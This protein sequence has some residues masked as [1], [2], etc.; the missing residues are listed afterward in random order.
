MARV[1]GLAQVIKEVEKLPKLWGWHVGFDYRPTFCRPR[2][3]ACIFWTA[4]SIG[5]SFAQVFID[6]HDCAKA[7][8]ECLEKAKEMQVKEDNK[9]K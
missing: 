8:S 9:N 6:G 4:P 1:K 5:C 7:L 2:T 3:E